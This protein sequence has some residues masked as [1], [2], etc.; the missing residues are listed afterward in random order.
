MILSMTGFGRA[1]ATYNDKEISVEIKSLNGKT[2]DLR[3]KVPSNFRDKEIEI[4]KLIMEGT[5]RGKVDASVV[6]DSK[7]G[8]EEYA[9]NKEL[10]T[11]YYTEL[12]ELNLADGGDYMQSI[13]RIPNVIKTE[14]KD[15]D[16]EEWNKIKEVAF[17]ALSKLKEYRKAEGQAT[18]ED[19]EK[20]VRVI[21]DKL[22]EIEPFEK[23]RIDKLKIRLNSKLEEF[24]Q[25]ERV[26]QNRFEQEV[27][28][29][30]EKLDINEEKVRLRQ[31]CHYF[32]DIINGKADVNGKKLGFIAQEM[33][34]EINTLGAKAQ[35]ANIQQRVV[36][37]KDELERIKEQVLNIV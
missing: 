18:K 1:S 27:V 5:K 17:L 25:S 20:S 13:L 26:D 7:Y 29:Y 21:I 19:F 37:M 28:Y 22:E 14:V 16:K 6:V 2:T 4:R 3:L 10:F 30:L 23:S 9:L 12:K 34:R 11:K 31:H 36:A 32:L 35:D 8:E 15:L 33:G 24:L